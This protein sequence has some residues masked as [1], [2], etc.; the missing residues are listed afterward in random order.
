MPNAVFSFRSL[1]IL[2]LKKDLALDEKTA[3]GKSIRP[4][5]VLI[6]RELAVN[7]RILLPYTGPLI[8]P[9]GNMFTFR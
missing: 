1:F 5:A 9:C 2:F 3:F 4:L 6:L 8:A 7:D